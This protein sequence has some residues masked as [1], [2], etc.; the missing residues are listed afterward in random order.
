MRAG[1]AIKEANKT[2]IDQYFYFYPGALVGSEL[3]TCDFVNLFL[4]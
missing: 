2:K 4:H 1:I 3:G